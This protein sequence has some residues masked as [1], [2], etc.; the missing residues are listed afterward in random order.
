MVALLCSTAPTYDVCMLTD[1][2]K[3]DEG[4]V[5]VYRTESLLYSP[6]WCKRGP[7]AVCPLSISVHSRT[8]LTTLLLLKNVATAAIPPKHGRK[9]ST[10]C[11][12]P[13]KRPSPR[14]SNKKKLNRPTKNFV[15]VTKPLT[16]VNRI[17]T[18]TLL[19]SQ[20]APEAGPEWDQDDNPTGSWLS[21]RRVVTE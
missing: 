13:C 3:S 1:G 14:T 8:E 16:K 6:P 10:W 19:L 2:T 15:F 18:R 20:F 11:A 5:F 12:L 21:S 7:K 4:T 9:Y 17:G